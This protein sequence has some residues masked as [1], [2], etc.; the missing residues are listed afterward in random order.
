MIVSMPT[1]SIYELPPAAGRSAGATLFTNA[2]TLNHTH[3]R[4]LRAQ[5]QEYGACGLSVNFSRR[6]FFIISGS[7]IGDTVVLYDIGVWTQG[8][9]IH[10]RG[11]LTSAIVKM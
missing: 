6:L 8:I 2:A 5:G 9:P 10:G 1:V 7:G 3:G 11:K 4:R